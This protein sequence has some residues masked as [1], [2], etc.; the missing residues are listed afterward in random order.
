M[1]GSPCPNSTVS[2]FN[3]ASFLM[4][5]LAVAISGV[6][7]GFAPI[8]PPSAPFMASPATSS[9]PTRSNTQMWP[10]V[11]PGVSMISSPNTLSPSPTGAISRGESIP[12]M[13]AA[14]A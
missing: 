2:K 9:P 6:N 8:T 11:W 5:S 3:A 1:T 10:G 7:C 13:S 12:A 14:P 4:D